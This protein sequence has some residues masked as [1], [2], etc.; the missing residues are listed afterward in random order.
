[1]Y[2]LRRGRDGRPLC[3]ESKSQAQQV[4]DKLVQRTT[5]T[6]C[7]V[8]KVV[9]DFPRLSEELVTTTSNPTA[10]VMS[11]E[12]AVERWA[13][14][15]GA[16]SPSFIRA[17][18]T[19]AGYPMSMSLSDSFPLRASFNRPLPPIQVDHAR[20]ERHMEGFT[21]MLHYFDFIPPAQLQNILHRYHATPELLDNDEQA[22]L[23]ACLCLGRYR[24]ITMT[25]LGTL[26]RTD[27]DYFR[28]AVL[29]LD[30]CT[31]ASY[32]SLRESPGATCVKLLTDQE[33]STAY[34]CTRCGREAYPRLA[35]YSVGWRS[36][37]ASWAYSAIA[38]SSS[39]QKRKSWKRCCLA[40]STKTGQYRTAS[41][42]TDCLSWY[43]TICDQAPFLRWSEID[44][45]LS[46][47]DGDMTDL[48]RGVEA[49]P[50]LVQLTV[51]ENDLLSRLH[52]G[53]SQTIT[54]EYVLD[55]EA[56]WDKWTKAFR[57]E[58]GKVSR[59]ML[60]IYANIRF[61]WYVFIL[62]PSRYSLTLAGSV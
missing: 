29:L 38:Q 24:E 35:I 5:D 1:M 50:F 58:Q 33:R 52:A 44:H 46:P 47:A 51:F 43:A 15:K 9:S 57:E 31:K 12:H 62:E 16:H 19:D 55:T 11:V 59:P 36:K 7:R 32:T 39:T 17:Y 42:P 23:F 45:D 8:P 28:R 56:R 20:D 3:S 22:L 27:A 34:T 60:Y 13:A 4:R 54:T 10:F 48:D 37:C 53:P 6:G 40:Q 41:C 26:E 14:G 30:Q 61:H 49:V 2:R 18:L 25:D 21:T